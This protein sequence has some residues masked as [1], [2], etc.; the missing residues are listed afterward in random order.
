MTIRASHYFLVTVLILCAVCADSRAASLALKVISCP[1]DFS[2]VSGLAPQDTCSSGFYLGMSGSRTWKSTTQFGPISISSASVVDSALLAQC[3]SVSNADSLDP[4]VIVYGVSH[5][6]QSC[7]KDTVAWN[8]GL[9]SRTTSADTMTSSEW[10]GKS[11]SFTYYRTFR[12]TGIVQELLN[13]SDWQS[14][15]SLAFMFVSDSA[16]SRLKQ[17]SFAPI[18]N[19]SRGDS[20]LIWY[21]ASAAQPGTCVL[22]RKN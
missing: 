2:F 8:T 3:N 9:S 21:H 7:I 16:V 14:G 22:M 18:D 6:N 1:H 13:R 11:A 12:V 4:T 19:A 5:K 10:A 20:L 17:R 15:D